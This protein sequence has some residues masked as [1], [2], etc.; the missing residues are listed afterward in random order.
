MAYANLLFGDGTGAGIDTS[1]RITV[2]QL[3][4]IRRPPEGKAVEDYDMDE[5]LGYAILVATVAF[6]GAFAAQDRRQQ[7]IILADEIRW[8]VNNQYGRDLIERQTLTGRAMGA[9]VLLVGQNVSHL[10]PDLHQHFTMRWA[11][12]ADS[13]REA[14]ATLEFLGV[15]VTP[16]NVE[17]LMSLNPGDTKGQCLV[18]DLTG[19]VGQAQICLLFED[20]AE[21]FKTTSLEE[22]VG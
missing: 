3:D 22:R 16:A 21:A 6:A 14:E 19:R 2:L 15:D 12:G 9:Q 18:R 13:E 8:F 20:L 5:Y 7:K 17:R 4:R 1:G 10:P 11:F